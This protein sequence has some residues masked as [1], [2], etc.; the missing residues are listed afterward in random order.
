MGAGSIPGRGSKILHAALCCQKKTKDILLVYM[1]LG[2]FRSSQT[3]RKDKQVNKLSQYN[4]I[5]VKTHDRNNRKVVFRWQ[6]F[7]GEVED[8]LL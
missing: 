8:G 3:N 7:Q 6:E 2:N 5:R 4:L 1:P